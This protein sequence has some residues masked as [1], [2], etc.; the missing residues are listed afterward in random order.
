[1]L[2]DDLRHDAGA[3]GAAAFADGEAQAVFH[4]DGRD[5]LNRELQVVARHHHF[6]ALGQHHR[7]GHV[8]GAEVE[9]RAVVGKERRV[10]ATLF[11]GQD[12]GLGLELGVRLDRTG[13]AQHLAALDTFTVHTAQ[14]CADVVARFPT[15]QELAEHLD[16]RA[17][18]GL[19][20][21]DAHDLDAVADVDHATLD[22]TGHNRAT[23][24]DREHVFDRHQERLV[25]GACGRRD[26]A[27]NRFHQRADRV[28]AD[29]RLGAVH[30]MQRRAAHDRNIVAGIVVGGQ[31]LADLHLDQLEQL[32]VIHLID[33]VH[34]DDHEGD[35]HLTTKQ[36]VL[37]RLRHRAVSRVHNQDRAIHLGGTG[38]HV[39]HIVGVAGAVDM[40]IVTRLGLI[41]HMRGR[42]R[43]PARLLFRRPVN[44]VIGPE[45]AEIL[46]D[47]RR[48]RR[49]A[50]VNVTNRAD[51]HMRLVTCKLFLCHCSGSFLVR[52]RCA[53]A[54][55]TGV[56]GW[57]N[58]PPPLCVFLL[59]L[60]RD[61][62]RNR[63]IMRELH[64][65][66]GASRRHRAQRVD[67]AEHIGQRHV[68]IDRNRVA[69]LLL[70]RN[71]PTPRRKIADD[72]A[73]IFLGRHD[74]DL[75]NRLEQLGTGLLETF[76]HAHPASNLERHDRRVHVVI[77]AVDQ[78]DLEVDHRKASERAAVHHRT[79]TLFD[80]R[81]I[82]LGHGTANDL[83][84]KAEAFARFCRR[85][86]QLDLGE[87]TRTTRLF[88]VGVGMLDHMADGL[89]VSHL[90]RTDIGLN[91]ELATQTVNQN[92]EMQFAHALHDRLTG[93]NIGLD[94]E[95]GVFCRQTGQTRR[96]FLLVAFGL[97]FNRDLD[98]RIGEGHGFQ[99]NRL[100][101]I[102][103]RVT[104]GGLFQTGQSDNV[105]CKR[106]F[107]LFAVDGMHHHH[108]ANA[109][110]LA[111]GRIEH[112]VTF[113]HLTRVNPGKGQRSHERVVHD[114]ER[115]C[116]ERLCI[117]SMA[118]DV[119]GL[120]LVI[121]AKAHVRRNVERRRQEV[122]HGIQK[123]L[124][125][126][127]LEG[128]ANQNGNKAERQRALADQRTQSCLIGLFAFEIPFHRV[129]VHFDGD[130]NQVGTPFV[131]HILEVVTDRLANPGRAQ[132]FALPD[133]FFHLDQV[134][135]AFE[136]IFGTDRQSHRRGDSPGAVLDHLDAVEEVSADL[137]HLVDEHETR[138]LVAVSLT[139]HGFGLRLDT[140]VPV[141]KTDRAIENRQRTLDF[142]G[143]V[144]VA[145]GVDD[146]EAVLGI[147]RTLCAR[148]FL[149]LPEGRGRGRSNGDTAFL[150]LL[151]PVHRCGAVVD[152]ADFVG[153]AG[154]EQNALGGR[155]LARIDV[156]HDPEIPVTLEGIVACHDSN[157]S[158]VY[159]R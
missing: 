11:L 92:V 90:R 19:G 51:V 76:A 35:A 42:D 25:H 44:L 96:H 68:C 156:G 105:A 108:P 117:I 56:V 53:M 72:V 62:V 45:L 158:E 39:L 147:R 41:F 121:R 32:F 36:D 142:N 148:I 67:I 149:T 140:G 112:R 134:D 155:G 99:N 145:G 82:F 38:D 81:D 49:L 28:L 157:A 124:H 6:G 63:L 59:D 131:G 75:H 16:A 130:F 9:L 17:G 106:L 74:F 55:P 101:R 144:D 21:A 115:E 37:A 150:L 110:F 27:V 15:I 24:R 79:D 1:M 52:M 84:F 60:F 123:R 34:V 13:L 100:G 73:G 50:M 118:R 7:A 136:L 128:R 14:E 4:G 83:A 133:P 33:L 80:T 88:L 127:V 138:H 116:R 78:R 104:R 2:L 153:L 87:L 159:Q 113:F 109:L 132:I 64:G 94:A 98:N 57:A 48:Q 89:T 5:Q 141:Q 125:A 18:G 30:R 85:D 120:G 46:G 111:L 122:D 58:C 126:L 129:V 107:D 146:V 103:E 31:Q 119:T 69:A 139:P 154:V 8:R 137:V 40:R 93:F 61:V 29:L 3:D 151:H 54:H 97:G 43:D 12:I 23:A 47:R 102:A 114:L 91:L 10:T 95:R 77:L 152:F 26:I 135:D 143:K 71:L 65:E 20:V 86:D 66:L 22:P 70:T